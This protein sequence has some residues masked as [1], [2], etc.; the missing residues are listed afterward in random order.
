L[1][2]EKNK[3]NYKNNNIRASNP[4]SDFKNGYHHFSGL[5]SACY[6]IIEYQVSLFPGPFVQIS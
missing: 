1:K 6:L 3:N 5:L 2:S 4:E